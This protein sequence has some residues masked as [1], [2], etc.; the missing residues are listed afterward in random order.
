MFD[1]ARQLDGRPRARSGLVVTTQQPIRMRR[2]RGA[3]HVGP[4][5]DGPVMRARG[6]LLRQ[7]EM[8]QR[9]VQSG[10]RDSRTG[11]GEMGRTGEIRLGVD[12]GERPHRTVVA[13]G[14]A[15]LHEG[16]PPEAEQGVGDGVARVRASRPGRSTAPRPAAIRARRSRNARAAVPPS[17]PGWPAPDDRA[18]GSPA[19]PG[20]W[21]APARECGSPRHGQTFPTRHRPP[22]G[23]TPRP[24]RG[25]RSR[26]YWSASCA[27]TDIQVT[28][29]EKLETL[30]EAPVQQPA[31]RRA[32]L[33]VGGLPQQVVREVVIGLQL[34]ED[35]AP[36]ELVDGTNDRS[37]PAG[38]WLR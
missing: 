38:H 32:H 1:A 15:P 29:V 5:A 18:P 20:G 6:E 24:G 37:R 34:A 27:D 2:E 35:A 17:P 10:Q 7:L 11:D 22:G 8:V 13:F 33:L 14:A 4:G 30:R 25:V 31:L 16:R 28:R 36:P 26:A 3:V 21:R 9:D 19:E 12:K 23:S